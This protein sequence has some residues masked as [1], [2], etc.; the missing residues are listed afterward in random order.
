M[1]FDVN[2]AE[3]RAEADR[4]SAE[5]TRASRRLEALDAKITR[6]ELETS[7]QCCFTGHG[8]L[9]TYEV[10]PGPPVQIGDYLRVYS[11]RT[12]RNELVQVRKFGSGWPGPHKIAH[13]IRIEVLD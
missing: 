2:L 8:Q 3:L 10:R 5:M 13:R 12:E 11:P 6:A 1:S 7:V 9:Y 4:I